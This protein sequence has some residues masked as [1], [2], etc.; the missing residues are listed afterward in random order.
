MKAYDIIV[1]LDSNR[2]WHEQEY[3]NNT[4]EVSSEVVKI[5]CIEMIIS[6]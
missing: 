6:D 5:C 1:E 4:L 2:S 3:F